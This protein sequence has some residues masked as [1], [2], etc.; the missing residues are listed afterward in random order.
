MTG[1]RGG[2]IAL[3]L[4]AVGLVVVGW[5]IGTRPP[6]VLEPGAP[7][8]A[9]TIPTG[10]PPRPT[11]PAPAATPAPAAPAGP[12]PDCADLPADPRLADAARRADRYRDYTDR[13][14]TETAADLARLW[15]EVVTRNDPDEL[16]AFLSVF[17][18]SLRAAGD[19]TL[20]QAL[21]DILNDPLATPAAKAAVLTLL[22][23]TAT[24]QA[25][26]LMTEAL[27]SGA[28][29]EDL[30]GTLREAIREASTALIEGDWNRAVSPVLEQAWRGR[31]ATLP[32]P[33]RAVLAQGLGYLGT[34][35]GTRALL[36]TLDAAGP[37][38]ETDRAI[39]AAALA[40]VQRNEAVPVL[41]QA[42]AGDQA[43]AS[44][45][46]VVMDALMNI[47]SADAW[48]SLTDYLSRVTAMDAGGREALRTGMAERGL[49]D[50]G[51]K[52]VR[53]AVEQQTFADAEVKEL[54]VQAL[55]S[56][57]QR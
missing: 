25:M 8:S 2:R 5:R 54:L 7:I 20:Y 15:P 35:P 48:L 33:G 39:A 30:A 4:A 47:G 52:V 24:P 41:A 37:A 1:R 23:R 32:A 6:P 57:L 44:V 45:T 18:E 19:T 34:A 3:I 16:P 43:D 26:A 28:A 10:Q 40:S 12:C 56:E 27:A 50:E 42:L 13:L 14:G 53:E 51:A 55:R 11:S 38:D 29:G 22:G 21:A 46:A 36:E 17:A 31:A 49:S 9:T